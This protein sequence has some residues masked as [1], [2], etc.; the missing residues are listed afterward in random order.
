M[1]AQGLY[2]P[3]TDADTA[4]VPCEL[5]LGLGSICM[6]SR[7]DMDYAK[8]GSRRCHNIVPVWNPMGAST[9]QGPPPRPLRTPTNRTLNLQKQPYGPTWRL[10]GLRKHL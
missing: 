9:N 6:V 10:M 3:S 7:K 4:L 8:E 2:G 5:G 1:G